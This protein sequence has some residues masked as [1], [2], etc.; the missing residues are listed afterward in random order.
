MI[1]MNRFILIGGVQEKADL[2]SLSQVIF[3]DDKI[4][5]NFL[6]CLFARNE[7]IYSWNDLF[8]QNKTFFTSLSPKRR[9][10]FVLAEENKFI[11][12][13]KV[14]N[15]IYFSGGD[16]IPLYT[17]L[18]RIGNGWLA[19]LKNK[20]VIGTSA[21]TDMLTKYNYDFQQNALADG[22]GIVPVKTIVHYGECEGYYT[23]TDWNEITKLLIDYKEELPLYTL[24]EGKFVTIDLE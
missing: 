10:N 23:N 24:A 16:S 13:V 19:E 7:N 2:A 8:E 9:I 15:I 6:I 1:K 4:S 12:Q 18:A 22:L 17:R 14:A 21:G 11:E 5:I 20:I 3:N